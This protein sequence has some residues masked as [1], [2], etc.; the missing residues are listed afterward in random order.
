MLFEVV[1][2]AINIWVL[3]YLVQLEKSKCDCALGLKHRII[4]TYLTIMIPL[5]L[6]MIGLQI[7]HTAAVPAFIQQHPK[8]T[9]SIYLFFLLIKIAF[10]STVF[11]YIRELKDT[12]CDCSVHNA[13]TALEI[14]NYFSIFIVVLL[15]ISGYILG[16][17]KFSK[18]ILK[19]LS[20]RF[21]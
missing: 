9:V 12:K 1:I 2:T 20:M 8:K 21:K 14:L 3:Y 19:G 7:M 18:T 11:L 16:S 15:L 4:K 13:R 5:A 17:S 6:I 10:I